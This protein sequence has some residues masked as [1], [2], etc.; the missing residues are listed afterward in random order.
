MLIVH[1]MKTS[2]GSKA[3]VTKHHRRLF[4]HVLTNLSYLK[5]QDCFFFF[6]LTTSVKIVLFSGGLCL[7]Y[8]LY[9]ITR[10]YLLIEEERK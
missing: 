6:I 8:C 2:L 3:T 4:L 9:N 1:H 5:I 7:C 10:N